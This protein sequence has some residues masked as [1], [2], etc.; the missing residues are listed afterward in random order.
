MIRLTKLAPAIGA[1]QLGSASVFN[2]PTDGRTYHK[3]RVQVQGVGAGSTVLEARHCI[4]YAQVLLDS[5][6][7]LHVE[8]KALRQYQNAEN[9]KGD[10]LRND[11]LEIP[12]SRIGQRDSDWPLGSFKTAQLSLQIASVLPTGGSP[13]NSLTGIEVWAEWEPWANA[14]LGT[15]VSFAKHAV[16]APTEG[17]NKYEVIPALDQF[18][19]LRGLFLYCQAAGGASGTLEDTTAYTRIR[20]VKVEIDEQLV[21]DVTKEM[22]IQTLAQLPHKKIPGTPGGFYVPCDLRNNSADYLA[23]FGPDGKRKPV[24]ITVNWDATSTAPL[25]FLIEGVR[26]AAP[27]PQAA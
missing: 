1:L 8:P 26:G 24:R 23:L 19:N 27:A 14:P 3:L 13:V 20:S 11:V 18:A 12:L 6:S 15:V 10:A 16:A 4:E 9:T 17:D 5:K 21:I 2:I 22:M 25:H 7:V